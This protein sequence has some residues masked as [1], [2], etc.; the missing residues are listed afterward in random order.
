MLLRELIAATGSPVLAEVRAAGVAV[1]EARATQ[2]RALGRPSR[3]WPAAVTAYPHWTT[4]YARAAA[5][6]GIELPLDVAV[7]QVNRWIAA[8]E[9]NGE[10]V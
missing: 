2:A 6:T 10:G 8:I 5:S 9:E 7:A 1:F 3:P 4:D